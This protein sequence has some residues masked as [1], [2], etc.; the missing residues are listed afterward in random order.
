MKRPWRGKLT[1]PVLLVVAVSLTYGL[2]TIGRSAAGTDRG[3]NA[4][5]IAP[6]RLPSSDV[7][8]LHG[9]VPLNAEAVTAAAL[10]FPALVAH[11]QA[12]AALRQ[13]QVAASAHPR[14]LAALDALA[15]ALLA[16]A[17]RAGALPNMVQADM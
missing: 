3:A 13:A 4:A 7:R 12:D 1:T 8:P 10:D 15:G 17:D 6:L 2:T 11:R 14:D 5:H 9:I 16:R